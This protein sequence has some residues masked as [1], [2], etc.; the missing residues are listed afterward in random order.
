MTRRLISVCLATYNQSVYIRDSVL[1]VL[2]QAGDFDVELL[3]GDDA[4]SDD[5]AQQLQDLQAK[6]PGRIRVHTRPSNIGAS[7]N[8]QLLVEQARGDFI[9]HLDGDDCWVP[10]KLAA[11]LAFM[12]RHPLCTAV[13]S[14]AAVVDT[15]GVLRGTFTEH[16]PEEFGID[17]LVSRGNFLN[18][19]SM[20]YR[21]SHKAAVLA[22]DCPFID[23]R[24]NLA[25]ACA[26]PLGFLPGMLVIYRLATAT[27]MMR[28]VPGHVRDM[29]AQVIATVLPQVA[30]H[31]QRAAVATFAARELFELRRGGRDPKLWSRIIHLGA[32]CRDGRIRVGATIALRLIG[33][34]VYAM[35]ARASR[36]FNPQAP[37]YVFYDRR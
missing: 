27:S 17:Y 21:A 2:S 1:G 23:Y 31:V 12:D 30:N 20:F 10:G 36:L 37:L 34:I 24:M 13:Y 4:S 29:N 14:N 25:L 11:Q 18:H 35:R 22:L 8:Y 33:L 32:G 5:T 9:A 6:Y 3:V 16:H 15:D 26:G 19:S 28:T 7:R